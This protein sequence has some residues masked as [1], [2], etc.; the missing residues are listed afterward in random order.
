MQRHPKA[1]KESAEQYISTSQQKALDDFKCVLNVFSVNRKPNS[2]NSAKHEILLDLTFYNK[3]NIL[4]QRQS[5]SE[6]QCHLSDEFKTLSKKA[7]LVL[8]PISTTYL[9]EVQ[10]LTYTTTKTKYRSLLNAE[11]DICL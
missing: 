10:F 8:L 7:K 11:S 4:F 2:L 3:L 9:C 6:F 1:L 5:L